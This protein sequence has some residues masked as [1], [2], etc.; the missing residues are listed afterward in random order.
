MSSTIKIF[1]IFCISV[2]A[3]SLHAQ[4]GIEIGPAFQVQS[5]WLLNDAD[6]DEGP[7]LD[8]KNTIQFSYGGLIG[9]GFSNRHGIRTGVLI[10]Q[11]GQE[12]TSSTE[13][14]PLPGASYRTMTE[15]MN[16]PVLYRYNG[17]LQMTNS[18]F[19]LT[20]GPQF[21]M[22]QSARS[23]S[24]I[25]DKVNQTAQL[26]PEFDSKNFFNDLDISAHLGI[27]LVARFSKHVHMNVALNLNYSL[28]DVEASATKPVDRPITRNAMGG[29]QISLFYFMG[30]NDMALKLAP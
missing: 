18:S 2:F 24:L 10:S 15:Y 1:I 5:T 4:K 23:T 19:L 20:V 27:G 9:Y 29:I 28:T 7:E 12:Y 14:K 11:Q 22:L 21:G 26:S 30:G 17:E 6:F 13:F 8:Y 16:I 25:Y 3:L